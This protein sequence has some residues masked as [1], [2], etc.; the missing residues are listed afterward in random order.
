VRR[1]Y[2]LSMLY[3]SRRITTRPDVPNSPLSL[4]SRM[5]DMS[6]LETFLNDLDYDVSRMLRR[7]RY[8]V[9]VTETLYVPQLDDP[10]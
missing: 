5:I 2:E 7:R 10:R 9:Q 6:S 8:T 3:R 1:K 4:S